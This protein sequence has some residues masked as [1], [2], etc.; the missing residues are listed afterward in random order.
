MNRVLP[1]YLIVRL[2]YQLYPERAV[3]RSPLYVV[4][5]DVYARLENGN[6]FEIITVPDQYMQIGDDITCLKT[7]MPY[8]SP[9]IKRSY[10]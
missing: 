7:G 2:G 1:G 5:H 8:H 4:T 3:F 9:N 10:L 6:Q